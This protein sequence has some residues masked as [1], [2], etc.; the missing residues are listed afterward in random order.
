MLK[1]L[2]L[3]ASC[4]AL[5]LP[6][7][8]PAFAREA[9]DGPR[10]TQTLCARSIALAGVEDS[11]D[12]RIRAAIAGVHGRL[13]P[14]AASEDKNLQAYYRAVD[15][16]LSTAKAPVLEQLQQSCASAF[17]P[18][19]LEAIN[20]FYASDAGKAWLEKGRTVIM[21]ALEQAVAEITP[22]LRNEVEQRYCDE[23]GLDCS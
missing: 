18:E 2:M 22:R 11:L 15:D 9:A 10:D 20:A 23:L 21:P 13:D 5:I 1:R 19:E 7:P 16:A 17:T 6:A 8:A 4:A 3:A 12:S 14:I